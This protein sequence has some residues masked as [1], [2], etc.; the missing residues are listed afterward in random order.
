MHR[1]F[2]IFTG[3]VGMTLAVWVKT[4]LLSSIGKPPAQIPQNSWLVNV[5]IAFVS[6]HML[7]NVALTIAIGKSPL[8]VWIQMDTN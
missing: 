1:K 4:V 2:L 7:L 3:F 5:F 6:I 8:F